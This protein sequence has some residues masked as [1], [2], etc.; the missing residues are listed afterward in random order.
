MWEHSKDGSHFDVQFGEQ[1]GT[2]VHDIAEGNDARVC[3]HERD[4]TDLGESNSG[5][6]AHRRL[7]SAKRAEYERAHKA[8]L[9]LLGNAG[10]YR[11]AANSGTDGPGLASGP[12]WPCAVRLGAR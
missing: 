1:I 4:E 2:V 11:R 7:L 5:G 9:E 12:V 8:R 10:G 6:H 3:A